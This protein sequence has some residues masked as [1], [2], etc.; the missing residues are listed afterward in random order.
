MSALK[1]RLLLIDD[2]PE[3]H[4]DVRQ[5][6]CPAKSH[7][8]LDE[9]EAKLL[10]IVSASPSSDRFEIDS[11]HQ[12]N[13]GIYFARK[14]LDE[15]RPYTAAFVDVRMP[16]GMD[17]I[18]TAAALWEIDPDLQ[19]V[20]CTAYS[21]Y[22]WEETIEKLPKIG[23]LLILKK[24]FEPVEIRQTAHSVIHRARSQSA[25][26]SQIVSLMRQ[27]SAQH[28]VDRRRQA[29]RAFRVA[30]RVR[31]GTNAHRPQRKRITTE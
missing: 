31:A 9:A 1:P 5:I 8:G 12:G 22:S 11:A 23:Q 19:I 27:L 30:P 15:G 20:I 14:A 26:K 28:I 18:E 13:E 25:D 7:V 29:A 16:P 10:G 21:D 17:G 2:N 6:L 3:I 4:R 24:P